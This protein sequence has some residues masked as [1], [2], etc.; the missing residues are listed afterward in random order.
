MGLEAGVT[1]SDDPELG[2]SKLG[3]MRNEYKKGKR[4]ALSI[5]KK[6]DMT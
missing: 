2:K 1:L 4:K 5:G 3:S 6:T